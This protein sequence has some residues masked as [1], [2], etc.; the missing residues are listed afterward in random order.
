MKAY[1][2]T[3]YIL[4]LVVTAALIGA[5]CGTT[6][7]GDNGGDPP[8]PPPPPTF[9][10]ST[11]ISPQ[12][13]G[14]V[15][16]SSGTF[17]EGSQVSVEASANDGWV[18]DGWT[19]DIESDS[20]PLAFS[21]TSNTSLTANFLNTSSSYL[22]DI[23]ASNSGDEIEL[24]F[25]QQSEASSVEAP[26]APPEGAFHVWFERD[27][28][29]L[30]TDI[31]SSSLTEVTWRLYLQPGSDSDIIE[32]AWVL[33]ADQAEGELTISDPGDT[34]EIDMFDEDSIDVDA[35]EV[36]YLIIRY[37]LDI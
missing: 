16:P 22:A 33:D 11:A 7:S 37:L 18:F 2:I 9:T 8:P 6:D 24:L 14:S 19:G 20:N 29:D 23:T 32:L 31:V 13:A 35:S 30:F 34:F 26:P 4:V 36:E 5:G 27:G 25:G 17:E 12:G 28:Q 21:I 3:L 1:N 15:S 10:L